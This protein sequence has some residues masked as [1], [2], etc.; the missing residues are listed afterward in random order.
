MQVTFFSN[1]LNHHQLP[2]CTELFEHSNVDFKFVATEPVPEERL[3]LGYH[4]M[5]DQY[6]FVLNAYNSSE[7]FN[8]AIILGNNSDVVI[9]GS[10][11]YLFVKKRIKENK[12]TFIY[13]ERI[14]KK[15][16]I[17]ILNPVTLASLLLKHTLNRNKNLYLLCASAYTSSDFSLVGSYKNKAYKWG[18]FP[19]VKKYNVNKLMSNKLHIVPKIVWVG[20]L[21]DWKHPDDVIKLAAILKENGYK[22]EIEIIGS[23]PM[24]SDLIELIKLNKL[25]SHIQLM[26]SMNHEEVRKRME[27]ANIFLFTSDFYEGWG[28]V[29]N[30][31]MNSGC[32]VVASHAIGSVPYLITNGINGLIYKNKNI[33]QLY[34]H[35]KYFLNNMDECQ[36][37]GI[38]AYETI[39]SLWNAKVAAKRL[40]HL[41][42]DIE[43]DRMSSK[44]FDGPCSKAEKISNHYHA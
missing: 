25:Q 29:L 24:E 27:S 31:A 36:K 33:K 21:L 8:K 2:L 26:G 7:D 30:E 39:T 38:N 18:Y 37:M 1:F 19:E 16:K 14:F 9:F 3:K 23:G 10:A 13:S 44:Y 32:G 11:P 20:R 6:T 35:V 12:L 43:R 5:N 28:A 34:N 4:N 17:K 40:I 42:N 15:G 22:F 41:F